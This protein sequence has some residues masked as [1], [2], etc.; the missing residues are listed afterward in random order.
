MLLRH[1]AYYLIARGLPGLINFIALSVYT[2]LLLP[3]DYGHYA[4]A[5]ATTSLANAALFQW[6]QVGLVRFMARHGACEER[7][8]STVLFSYMIIVVATGVLGVVIWVSIQP[9]P[10]KEILPVSIGLFWVQGWF[11]INLQLLVSR[12]KPLRYGVAGVG[13][14]VLALSVGVILIWAGWRADAP[15]W[16]FIVGGSVAAAWLMRGEWGGASLRRADPVILRDLLHYGLPLGATLI[17]TFVVSTLDRYLLAWFIDETAAGVYSAGH[18]LTQMSLSVMMMTVNLA[19]YP[20]AVQALEQDGA[21]VARKQLWHQ[22]LLL[23]AIAGPITA[24]F[25]V[26]A[27]NIVTVLLGTEFQSAGDIIP[28]VAASAFMGG[29]KACY[30]DLAFQLG[31]DTVKQI[32]VVAAATVINVSLNLLW[33]PRYGLVGAAWASVIALAAGLILSERLGRCVF[34]LPSISEHGVKVGAAVLFMVAVLWPWRELLG[35]A[36]LCYQVALGGLAYTMALLVLNPGNIRV[37]VMRQVTR[38]WSA[39]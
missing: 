30:Y 6:L 33:I 3:G 19:A 35:V 27:E 4:L 39:D 29:L 21:E 24:G 1:S 37:V 2:N 14:A 23:L 36:A 5:L 7:L 26:L 12:L 13:R 31:R 9:G 32:W 22:G 15:L 34:Q 10:W 25:I 8:T 16:G 11:E 17:L 20:I 28:W 38:L 18:D